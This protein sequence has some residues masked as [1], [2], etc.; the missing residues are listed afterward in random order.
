MEGHRRRDGT[1]ICPSSSGF[2]PSPPDSPLKSTRTLPDGP[3]RPA[4]LPE[5]EIP[6]DVGVYRRPNPNW[7]NAPPPPPPPSSAVHDSDESGSVVST[8][9]L[10]DGSSIKTSEEDDD[11]TTEDENDSVIDTALRTS[12]PLASIFSTPKEHIADVRKAASDIG[13]HTGLMRRPGARDDGKSSVNRFGQREDSWWIILGRNA[14]AVRHLVN[15]Q[16][17]GMPG[18]Y[19]PDKEVEVE[20]GRP[21]SVGFFQMFLA[22]AIGGAAVLFGMARV[23]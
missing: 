16:Q 19:E 23:L 7:V 10:D 11:T 15:I 17:R 4:V 12:I 6:N 13:L 21:S 18:F 9:L 1:M 20:V 22:G 2:L 8:I 14:E 3:F 5:I